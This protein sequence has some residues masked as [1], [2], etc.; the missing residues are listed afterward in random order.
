M[1]NPLNADD[2]VGLIA[3]LPVPERVRLLRLLT[4]RPLSDAATAYEAQPPGPDEFSVEGDPLAWDAD[5]WETL[6]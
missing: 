6:G 3:G 2:L 1:A 4:R 5:G